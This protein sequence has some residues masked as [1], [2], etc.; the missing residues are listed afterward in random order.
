MLIR[1]TKKQGGLWF[2][3]CKE[4]LLQLANFRSNKVHM[5]IVSFE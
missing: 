5:V 4:G 1:S 3:V 2:E